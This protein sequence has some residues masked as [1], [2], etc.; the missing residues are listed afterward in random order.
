[1]GIE[2][3]V[4]RQEACGQA[5]IDAYKRRIEVDGIGLVLPEAAAECSKLASDILKY[6]YWDGPVEL[7]QY[8]LALVKVLLDQVS[9]IVGKNYIIAAER[10][11]N[12]KILQT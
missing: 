5:M 11:I 12:E 8:Q 4:K 10:K 3:E 2:S 6:L 1:M 7:V 9:L